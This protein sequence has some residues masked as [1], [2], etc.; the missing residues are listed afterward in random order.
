MEV[1]THISLIVAMK[2]LKASGNDQVWR[3][4]G[5]LFVYFFMPAII[6]IVGWVEVWK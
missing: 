4:I 1:K 6:E 3:E 5:P 2:Y